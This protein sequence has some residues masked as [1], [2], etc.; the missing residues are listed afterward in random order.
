MNAQSDDFRLI[1]IICYGLPFDLSKQLYHE[2]ENRYKEAV[3][4]IQT[5]AYYKPI[6][7]ELATVNVLL[8]LSIFQKRVIANLDSALNFYG[9]VTRLSDAE[10]IKI[11]RYTLDQGEKNQIQRVVLN[12]RKLLEKYAISPALF[13]YLETKELLRKLVQLKNENG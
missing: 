5:Y 7:N 2:F 12:Y 1:R 10:A 8:A 9:S 3:Y 13:D 4:L 6:R 11:G